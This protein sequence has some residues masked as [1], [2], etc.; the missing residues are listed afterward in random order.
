ML[1]KLGYVLHCAVRMDYGELFRTVEA[2]CKA[3]GRHRLEVLLDVVIC[4]FRYGAGFNDYLLCEFYNL[5]SEQRA[6]YVTRSV[7]NT[8]VQLLNDREYY[9]IFDNKSEFY[10]KFA[11]YIGREWLDFS[12][13]SR[14]EFV[15]FFESREAVMVKP[16]DGTGGKGVEKLYRKD[17]PDAGALFDSLKAGR[18]G[19]VEEVLLQ[20]PDLNRMNPSSINTLRV[21]TIL[22]EAGPNIVYAHIRIGNGGR[23]VDNLHSG[24]MF[25][26]IK[27][28]T[29][30][31]QYPGYD[32]NRKTYTVHPQTGVEIEGF[33]IPLW[34]EAKAL[35][36]EAAKLVP[37]MRYVGWD[38]AVTP[39]GPVLVEGNNLP[40]YDI[41]Q[42][43]PHT[44]DKTGMLPRFRE[45]V[46]GI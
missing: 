27:M 38:V 6:T 35:C 40:G 10:Q 1:G 15:R 26:P 4:G 44:P 9:H 11:P 32:K 22:N 30:R 2:V 13:A 3:T 14:E 28:D 37:Q 7:N 21:V 25:A 16:D 5:T 34:E 46:D 24:G 39:S 23:P 42:M 17:Y 45:F 33:Q 8:L 43:P 19:V 18:T 31:V 20:H 41:L 36:L 12:K 29:G